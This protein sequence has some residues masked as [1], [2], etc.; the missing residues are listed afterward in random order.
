M[1][2]IPDDCAKKTEQVPNQCCNQNERNGSRRIERLDHI[3]RLN[4][5]RPKNEIDDRLR[6]PGQNQKRPYYV[7]SANQRPDD[8]ADFVRISHNERSG[9]SGDFSRLSVQSLAEVSGR[10]PEHALEETIKLR[11]RLK[12]DIVRDF[13]DAFIWIQQLRLRILEPDTCDV[14]GEF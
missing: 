13:A 9:M 12:P 7:P 10:L 3:D 1:Q 4:H 2:S 11:E 14:I 5:V 6:P 8:Q